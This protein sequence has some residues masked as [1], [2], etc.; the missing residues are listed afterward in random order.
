MKGCICHFTTWQIHPFINK[1]KIFFTLRYTYCM[2]DCVSKSI[3]FVFLPVNDLPMVVHLNDPQ[4]NSSATFPN[5]TD[6][7]SER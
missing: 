2:F 5:S 3:Y 6:F 7:E 4:E 1:G